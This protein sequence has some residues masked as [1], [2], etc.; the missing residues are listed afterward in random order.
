MTDSGGCTVSEECKS[1]GRYC[2]DSYNTVCTAATA[3]S[4]CKGD[5]LTWCGGDDPPT[6]ISGVCAF[7]FDGTV[8]TTTPYLFKAAVKACEDANFRL[9]VMTYNTME[10]YNMCCYS[11][12][13]LYSDALCPS[14][15][16]LVLPKDWYYSPNNNLQNVDGSFNCDIDFNDATVENCK[17]K[18]MT[19][20]YNRDQSKNM[21]IPPNCYVLWDDNQVNCTAFKNSDFCAG[22]SLDMSSQTNFGF[23]HITDNTLGISQINID[24]FTERSG[25][26]ETCTN[27]PDKPPYSFD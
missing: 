19:D 12:N 18:G 9:A 13:A 20:I 15:D 25:N 22:D 26:C 7:D 21:T 6:E 2:C 10:D 14:G 8:S 4:K 5:D 27:D 1:K 16:C 3:E 17:V 24:Y 11:N 23:V